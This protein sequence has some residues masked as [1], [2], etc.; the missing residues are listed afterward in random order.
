MLWR[1]FLLIVLIGLAACQVRPLYLDETAIGGPASPVADL[2]SI[3]IDSPRD[4]V[5]LALRNELLFLF[6]GDG[7]TVSD[8]RYRLRLITLV[9]KNTLAVELEEDLPS[10]VFLTVSSTFILSEDGSDRTLLTGQASAGASYDFSSNRFANVRAE[11]D[12]EERAA[13][14]VA[15]NINA[16]VASYFAATNES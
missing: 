3:A 1:S 15:E 11:R 2:Q 5:E 6:R 16:R 12:A 9:A 14:I 13:R 10:A 4:R 8:P 7:S